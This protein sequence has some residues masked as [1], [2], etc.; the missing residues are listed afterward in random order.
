MWEKSQINEPWRT[1]WERRCWCWIDVNKVCWNC[2]ACLVLVHQ[3]VVIINEIIMKLHAWWWH[4][5]WYMVWLLL[6]CVL[7]F[8]PLLLLLWA[9][10]RIVEIALHYS[11]L[12]ICNWTFY[13]CL[14]GWGSSSDGT[15]AG[16]CKLRQVSWSPW[17]NQ[18]DMYRPIH[19]LW[20]NF[21]LFG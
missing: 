21:V 11:W 2:I 14:C 7:I 10:L 18:W 12:L 6:P 15:D 4:Y 16:N 5:L 13:C 20:F 17:M 9:S 1:K 3:F 8:I 19:G